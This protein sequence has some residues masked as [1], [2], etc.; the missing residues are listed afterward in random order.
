MKAASLAFSSRTG[1]KAAIL[2]AFMKALTNEGAS[3]EIIAPKVG[4]A[5]VSD[6]S[7]IA[8]DQMIDGGP[9]VFYDAVALLPCR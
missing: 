3:F 5:K 6:G 4:G 1:T 8:A 2:T 9:S 7:L